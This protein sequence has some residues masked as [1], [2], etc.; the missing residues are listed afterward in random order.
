MGRYLR[1]SSMSSSFFSLFVYELSVSIRLN[2]AIGIFCLLDYFFFG[3]CS[4]DF[5]FIFVWFGVGYIIVVIVLIIWTYFPTFINEI[6]SL[7]LRL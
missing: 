5:L 3:L 6:F 2:F 4:S 7:K 1:S